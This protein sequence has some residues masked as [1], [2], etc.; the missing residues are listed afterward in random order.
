[1]RLILN[2]SIFLILIS[3]SSKMAAQGQVDTIDVEHTFLEDRHLRYMYNF[4]LNG[5]FFQYKPNLPHIGTGALMKNASENKFVC[6]VS[7]TFPIKMEDLELFISPDTLIGGKFVN[8]FDITMDRVIF[9]SQFDFEYLY[10]SDHES[11]NSFLRNKLIQ[12]P[13]MN[14][15]FRF[16]NIFLIDDKIY[17]SAIL[18]YYANYDPDIFS[19]GFQMYEF[20]WCESKKWIYPSRVSGPFFRHIKS[21]RGMLGGTIKIPSLDCPLPVD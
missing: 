8:M 16:S 19:S 12:N 3:S 21:R 11:I 15:A 10:H 2:L 7:N 4:A 5:M 9:I 13:N 1:M 20:K 6:I 18:Y 14:Y 17:L